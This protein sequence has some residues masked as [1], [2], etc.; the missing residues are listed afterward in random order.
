MT[1]RTQEKHTEGGFS[2]VELIV[3]VTIMSVGVLGYASSSVV[4]EQQV[5][6]AAI[7]SDRNSAMVTAVE[8]VR[9]IDFDT[10]AS[11]ADSVGGYH[12]DW[13]VTPQ[14][15]Y[16]KEVQVVTTGRGLAMASGGGMA[17]TSQLADTFM[18]QVVKP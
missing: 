12:I 7:E 4:L 13:S 6:V 11:G 10:L 16:V 2:L 3:S 9:A 17:V 15:T 14:G 1:E 5:S 18:Y 8:R